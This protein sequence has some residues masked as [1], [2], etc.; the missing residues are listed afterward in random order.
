M[1][2][3]FGF[4]AFITV[5][6]IL[7]ALFTLG[8]GAAITT[9]ILIAIEIAFSFDNAV[10]NAKVLARLSR[11]WQQLFLTVG[12]LIAVVGMRFVFPILIVMITAG[13]PGKEVIDLALN[14]P[15]SYAR[16][17]EE[18]HAA[19]SAFGGAFL[20]TLTFYFFF[21]DLR[22][23]LWINRIERPLQR[24]GGSVWLPPLLTAAIVI[25]ASFFL[26]HDRSTVLQAGLLGTGLYTGLKLVIDAMDKLA[27]TAKKIYTGWPALFALLYLEVLDASFSF[28]GV[29]GA[30]AITDMVLVIA[31]GLGVGAVWVRSMTVYMV[32]F[33]TLNAYK[34]LE[35]GAHY[36]ILF[37]AVALFSGLFIK[38][39]EAIIGIVGLGIIFA[40]FQASREALRAKQR[41]ED[42]LK[43]TKV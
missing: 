42:L 24:I 40:S 13:L 21:D 20:L 41:G 26:S 15:D 27:P 38:I 23:V 30:F 37:L 12:I 19:I 9:A 25:I 4:S 43:R 17:L 11:F 2:R 34:Y 5:G 1:L 22:E 32:R 28:D 35:H 14:H 36:A 16:H 39:P 7:L 33:G 6:A 29:L 10:I 3:I 8:P 31:L 18:A